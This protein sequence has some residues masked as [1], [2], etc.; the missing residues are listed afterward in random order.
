[1][2][3]AKLL[4]VQT[5][6]QLQI[7]ETPLHFFSIRKSRVQNLGRDSAISTALES[8]NIVSDNGKAKGCCMNSQLMGPTSTVLR[9]SKRK[10]EATNDENRSSE[11]E[12]YNKYH[13]ERTTVLEKRESRVDSC[14]CPHSPHF[15]G[16]P[17]FECIRGIAPTYPSGSVWVLG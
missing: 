4:R 17:A 13:N 7:G 10:C 1:M 15:H 5:Q 9:A 3:E 12:R 6:W 16:S 8:V 14:C 11:M 2:I